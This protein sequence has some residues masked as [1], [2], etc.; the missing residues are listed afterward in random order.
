MYK[1]KLKCFERTSEPYDDIPANDPFFFDRDQAWQEVLELAAF[2]KEMLNASETDRKKLYFVLADKTTGT[3]QVVAR[4]YG[5]EGVRHAERI[6][7]YSVYE[8]TE[9]STLELFGYTASSAESRKCPDIESRSEVFP[10]KD[11]A[12]KAAWKAYEKQY[13]I[14][15]DFGLLTPSEIK[16]KK[17]QFFSKLWTAADPDSDRLMLHRTDRNISFSGWTQLLTFGG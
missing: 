7:E 14:A 8:V 15:R 3:A 1:I 10:S 9:P 2:E 13:Q 6:T 11:A 5:S 16:L 4:W 12:E 17:S